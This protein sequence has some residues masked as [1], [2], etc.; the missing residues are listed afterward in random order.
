MLISTFRNKETITVTQRNVN[1]QPK[2]SGKANFDSRQIYLAIENRVRL[3]VDIAAEKQFPNL[4][5]HIFFMPRKYRS[6]RA[7]IARNIQNQLVTCRRFLKRLIKLEY[8]HS[9]FLIRAGQNFQ[10]Y[11]LS[12]G[13]GVPSFSPKVRFTV[14]SSYDYTYC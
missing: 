6:F 5:K 13:L 8:Q 12:R 11:Q 3:G 4:S 1:L 10:L 9:V 7:P 14:A 2:K